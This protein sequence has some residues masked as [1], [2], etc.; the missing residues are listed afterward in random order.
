[1]QCSEAMTVFLMSLEGIRSPATL[2]CYKSLL[3]MLLTHLGDKDLAS[4]TLMDLRVCR[5]AVFRESDSLRTRHSWVILMRRFFRW[6]ME[7]GLLPTNIAERLEAP[8]LEIHP[9]PGIARAD[10]LKMLAAARDSPR[11]YALLCFVADTG[12]RLG[13]VA[14]LRLVD[15]DLENRTAI[16]LEKGNRKR[17]V[18][19]KARTVEALKTYLERRPWKQARHVFLG[20][21]GQPLRGTGI[22]RTFR[23]IAQRVGIAENWSP[24]QWRHGAARGMLRRGANLA[25]VSQILGHK[26]VRVTVQFY[27]IFADKELQEAHDRYS[28][29]PD[30]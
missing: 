5:S 22:Y 20:P 9:R 13:G 10:M 7:E 21:G 18:F 4:V 14:G 23:R 24:H 30:D 26:D 12:C 17:A 3:K 8:R 25:Q 29:L 16:V 11:D 2:A 28:W 15:L 6:L 27:G 1:M 19:F